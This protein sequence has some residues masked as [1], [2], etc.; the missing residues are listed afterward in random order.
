MRTTYHD[1]DE[2]TGGPTTIDRGQTTM[3]AYYASDYV[4]KAN[5]NYYATNGMDE[6]MCDAGA[7]YYAYVDDAVR[8]MTFLRYLAGAASTPFDGSKAAASQHCAMVVGINFPWSPSSLDPH[9]LPSSW[10][11]HTSAAA[12]AAANSAI[13]V[14][15]NPGTSFWQVRPTEV[16]AINIADLSSSRLENRQR[17]LCPNLAGTAFGHFC[18]QRGTSARYCA[19]CHHAMTRNTAPMPT[20][21]FLAFPGDGTIHNALV[22]QWFSFAVKGVSLAGAVVTLNGLTANS[23]ESIGQVN[24][25]L[26]SNIIF[27][28][29]ISFF[30]CCC[31]YVCVVA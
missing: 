24:R 3:C 21:G 19:Q 17:M 29:L 20:G 8:R 30:F 10:T 5:P 7:A 28:Q 22:P 9:T 18:Y 4:E 15:S 13:Y 26:M 2:C 11:C 14:S 31:L 16:V 12:T 27:L 25:M 23:L 6:T 1:N